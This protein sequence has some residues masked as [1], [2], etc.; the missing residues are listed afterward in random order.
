MT[1]RFRGC[2]WRIPGGPEEPYSAEPTDALSSVLST[3]N[4]TLASLRNWMLRD[5]C[6]VLS[7]AIPLTYSNVGET[8][9]PRCAP[10]TFTG[11]L[12][13]HASG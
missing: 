10:A 6:K 11:R 7:F 8:H 4:S 9:P 2:A 13:L 5:P 1:V 12:A 3:G